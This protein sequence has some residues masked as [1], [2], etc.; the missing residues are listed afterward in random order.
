MDRSPSSRPLTRGGPR[1]A[2]HPRL[3]RRCLVPVVHGHFRVRFLAGMLGEAGLDLITRAG[4]PV[5][6]QDVTGV[7]ANWGTPQEALALLDPRR[8]GVVLHRSLL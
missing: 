7:W 2:G 3:E 6:L 5:P 1:L 8:A 4:E